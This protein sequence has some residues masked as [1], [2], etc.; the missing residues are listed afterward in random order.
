MKTS[1]IIS[2]S[3]PVPFEA[4]MGDVVIVK[5][6]YVPQVIT[7]RMV[8]AMSKSMSLSEQDLSAEKSIS[9]SEEA[10]SAQAD[11][12]ALS[13]I[14]WDLEGEDGKPMPITKESVADLPIS[15]RNPIYMAIMEAASPNAATA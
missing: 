15:I 3:T 5:G 13:I 7:G 11:V 4:K 2:M 6:T 1:E 10:L 9:I 14:T 8:T 12:L